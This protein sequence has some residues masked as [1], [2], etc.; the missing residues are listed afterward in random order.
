M[1]F[2]EETLQ[3]EMDIKSDIHLKR[4]NFDFEMFVLAYYILHCI[5]AQIRNQPSAGCNKVI[6]WKVNGVINWLND[7]LCM[8]M[9]AGYSLH[10]LLSNTRAG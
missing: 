2:I 7:L 3:L 1:E 8:I 5:V 9:Y 6:N 4:I 10:R